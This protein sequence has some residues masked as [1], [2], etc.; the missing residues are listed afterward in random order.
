LKNIEN[1]EELVFI[2]SHEMGHIKN[3][4]VLKAYTTEVP[5]KLTL[6]LL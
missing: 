2:M 4:D 3:R 1:Q 6:S 5:L